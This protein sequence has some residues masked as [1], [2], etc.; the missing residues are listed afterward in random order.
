MV[1]YLSII[2]TAMTIIAICNITLNPMMTGAS[3]FWIIAMV[4][5]AVA[6]E[7]IINLIAEGIIHIMPSKWF[8]VDSRFHVGRRE[9]KFYEKLG[10]KKWKEKVWELGAVGGFSKKVIIDP[11]SS[12]YLNRYVVECNKGFVG[13]MITLPMSFLILLFPEPKYWLWIGLPVA[14][15]SVTLNILPAMILRYNLP[16]L[17][18]AYK[19]ALSKEKLSEKNETVNIKVQENSNILDNNTE[20]SVADTLTQ[21]GNI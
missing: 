19:R 4:V 21:V 11:N 5:L 1:L 17:E 14:V 7:V 20:D 9:R 2:L 10:I 3:P 13:H 16:K 18:V 6:V 8:G 15:V 12:A